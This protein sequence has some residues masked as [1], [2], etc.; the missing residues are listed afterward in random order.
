MAIIFCMDDV[1]INV[2]VEK[3]KDSDSS[4]PNWTD[5]MVTGRPDSRGVK[6]AMIIIYIRKVCS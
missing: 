4:S 3:R 5:E 2:F 6:R 1:L